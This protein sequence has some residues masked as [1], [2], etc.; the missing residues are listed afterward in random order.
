MSTLQQLRGGIN[1]AIDYLSDGWRQLS[2]RATQAIT[3]FNPIHRTGDDVEQAD[4]VI[5]RNASR[6]SLL[7][8]DVVENPGEIVVKLEAPGLEPDS[9]DI[10]VVDNYVVI[11]GEKRVERESREGRY[12]VLECAYGAFERAVP[13]PA[14]VDES[15]ASARYKNGVLRVTLPKR[16]AQRGGRIAV[17]VD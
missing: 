5:E 4:A 9:F 2:E 15:R 17:N 3:H 8:A 6:W 10:Q 16:T 14:A 1:R 12:H 7:S 13:I 11:R